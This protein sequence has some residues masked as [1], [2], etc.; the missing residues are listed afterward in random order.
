MQLGGT[1]VLAAVAAGLEAPFSD[2]SREGALRFNLEL[3]PM[4]SPAFEAG[5]MGEDAVELARIVERAI[6][7]SGA[8]D[9][10]ALCVLPGR[11]VRRGA[12]LASGVVLKQLLCFPQAAG[13]VLLHLVATAEALGSSLAASSTSAAGA[14]A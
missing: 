11:K 7:Q 4:A 9:M 1:R 10:E 8:I 14:N 3:S 13:A 2:R 6:K 12:L 5:R